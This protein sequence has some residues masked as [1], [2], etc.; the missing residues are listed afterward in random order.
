MYAKVAKLALN[1]SKKM[2]VIDKT[3]T[4]LIIFY[5]LLEDDHGVTVDQPSRE[6]QTCDLLSS[7]RDF[8]VA[9]I[10]NK[11]YVSGGLDVIDESPVN[12]LIVYDGYTGEWRLLSGMK[13]NR[14]NHTMVNWKGRLLVTGGEI[15]AHKKLTST[16]EVYYPETDKWVLIDPLPE[17]RCCHA[18]VVHDGN[19]FLSGGL[20]ASQHPQTSIWIYEQTASKWLSLDEDYPVELPYRL[21]RHSMISHYDTIYII[22]GGLLMSSEGVLLEKTSRKS[23]EQFVPRNWPLW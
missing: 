8:A 10:D 19:V 5:D 16:C 13:K 23:L 3:A 11:V 12:A 22:G 7:I 20:C 2:M 14:C 4:G 18:C 15:N 17:P 1:Q 6:T 9:S 21:A